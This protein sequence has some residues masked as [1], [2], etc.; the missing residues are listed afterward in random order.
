[1][2]YHLNGAVNIATLSDFVPTVAGNMLALTAPIVLTPLI[3][4]LKPDNYD[5][6]RFKEL[7]QVDDSDF[8]AK[9][10]HNHVHVKTAAQRTEDELAHLHQ[11]E[12]KL[13]R[14]R[15]IALVLAIFIAVSMTM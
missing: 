3:T 12:K 10:T 1:M 7:K 15:N 9:T 11:I 14:A 13:F 5:F 8:V 6:E 2:A 4:Y